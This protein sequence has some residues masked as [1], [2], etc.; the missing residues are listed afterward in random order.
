MVVSSYDTT[1]TQIAQIVV[2]HDKCPNWWTYI[3]QHY[4]LR[5]FSAPLYSIRPRHKMLEK[6]L[7]FDCLQSR[8]RVSAKW[9]VCNIVRS[10]HGQVPFTYG[11]TIF[12][13]LF[14]TFSA[15]VNLAYLPFS[16]S[17]WVRMYFSTFHNTFVSFVCT[18][19]PSLRPLADVIIL[20]C[21]SQMAIEY[22]VQMNRLKNSQTNGNT[23]DSPYFLSITLSG[24][25]TLLQLI[26]SKI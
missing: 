19:W 4:K 20:S 17:L 22:C 12:K 13:K 5:K 6:Y 16:S 18:V 7:L 2:L 26:V 24:T 1:I 25:L 21:S 15:T 11:P 14:I 10:L 8:W 9:A 23:S 3:M